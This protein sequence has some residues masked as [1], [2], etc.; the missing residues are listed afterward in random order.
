MKKLLISPSKM[1]LG[2]QENNI[3]QN[4]LKQSS[5]L[6]LNLMAVK[7]ENHP[8]DFLPWCYELLSASR[9]RMN[10]DLL[11]PQQ[12][13][14]LK[15]LHDQLISAISFLQVKTLRIAPWPVV[16]VFVEQHKDVI[17]LDE[18][19]RLV[20][21]IKSIREQSLKDMIPEDLLAF[22]GK[23]MASLD[24]STYNFDV[25]WFASTKSAKSFHQMLAD[26]PGA[27]DDALANIPLEG[28]ITQYEYQ[29]FV[30]AYSK[31]F[32]DNG[33]KPTLAPATRLLAMRR[34]DLFTPITNNRLDALCG[35]LGVPK[36]KNSDFERYWQDIVKG[37][38]AMSW[39]KMANA[40][41]ELEEQLVA[42]KALIPCFF[43]YADDKTPDSS[44][45][46]KLLSKPKRSTTTTGKTQ[47]RGKESAEI[48]VDRALAADDIPEHIRSK[49]DSIINEVQKG[50]GV[51]ETISLMRTIFG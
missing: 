10:Y 24:P 11:E 47:R 50:R 34:P 40:S 41:N 4:I 51:N 18:Q 17:A 36:L 16:S 33:E 3:Y 1:T 21:Y 49:R 22:S 7:V 31:V 35:A 38:Q 8:D 32:T 37:I 20:S 39:Y 48:L 23:H 5:E 45:Y 13:P 12:L 6:S 28:D 9:D 29:Q 14:V 42:I 44:N 26:L 43:Y 30:A 46:I 19:L 15:K 25:E 2:E 27:F